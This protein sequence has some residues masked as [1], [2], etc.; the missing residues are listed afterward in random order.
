MMCFW[1]CL[2]RIEEDVL[3]VWLSCCGVYPV[4]RVI[5]HLRCLSKACFVFDTVWIWFPFSFKSFFFR[6]MKINKLRVLRFD[7]DYRSKDFE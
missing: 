7:L 5:L 6:D 2:L 4:G 1:L 3:F